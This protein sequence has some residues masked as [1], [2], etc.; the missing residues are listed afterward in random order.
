MTTKQFNSL[1]KA[2]KRVAVAKDVLAQIKAGKY[3]PN[4]GSYI[5]GLHPEVLPK[6][7]RSLDDVQKNFSKLP[8]CNVCV[9]GACILSIAHLGD[10][11]KIYELSRVGNYGNVY[12]KNTNA[13][14]LS[15]FSP[16][17]LAMIEAAFETWIH[18]M[19]WSGHTLK[20]NF[21]SEIGDKLQYLYKNTS[22]AWR[23]EDIMNNIIKNK[24]TF[25]PEFS[26]I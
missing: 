20:G 12:G 22:Y 8:Q 14:I 3:I 26:K 23:L 10:E 5:K 11:L 13:K 6:N 21:T 1:S 18:P 15:V 24:G 25:K 2:E 4:I 16:H 9:L 19:G 17:Q 7:L